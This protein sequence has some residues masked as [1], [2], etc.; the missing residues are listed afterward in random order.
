MDTIWELTLAQAERT[1]AAIAIRGT[2]D[3]SYASLIVQAGQLALELAERTPAGRVIAMELARPSMAAAVILAAASC[4]C[5]VLP[6]NADSPAMHREFVLA[7]ARPAL[8]VR[9]LADGSYQVERLEDPPRAAE[10]SAGNGILDL[11]RAAYV[12]YTSGSTG[13]PKGVIISHEALLDR[14]AAFT[15]MPGFGPQDAILSMTAPSFDISMAELLVPLTVG[16]ALIAAP[17]GTGADPAIFAAAV[18]EFRPTVI[19]ATPSFW[20]LA[21][22]WGWTGAPDVRIWCGGEALTPSLAEQLMPRCAELWNMYGPT[23]ATIWVS[24]SR[25]LA[26]APIELGQPLPGARMCL[27]GEDGQPVTEPAQPAELLLYGTGLAEGYLNR[28]E[29]TAERFLTCATPDGPRR[30]YRTGDLAEYRTDGSLRFLGR[31]DG[32]IKLR[33]HR[34]ELSE[35]EAVAEEQPGVLEAAAVLREV[36]DSERTHIALFVVTDGSLTDREI[37]L[38]LAQRLPASMRPARVLIEAALPR[39]TSGKLDRVSLAGSR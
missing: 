9:G 12:I 18:A 15:R 26:G 36:E 13:R 32:Q 8:L 37:R 14:L 5:P 10:P 6:L 29:L 28:A 38:W 19:Q 39:N 17:A 16:G 25:V 2:D 1:P 30:C 23:E 11:S 34:I 4:H 31:A 7:D 22:A 21:L 27:A 20:R 3:Q 33:G 24:I 35:I